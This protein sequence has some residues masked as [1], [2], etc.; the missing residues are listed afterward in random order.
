MKGVAIE[1]VL[2]MIENMPR[3]RL[4][5][6]AFTWDPDKASENFKKHGVTFL[7][8]ATSFL[9]PNGLDG[10]DRLDPSREELIAY[11]EQQRLL[12]TVYVEVDGEIIRIISARRATRAERRAY[13]ENL[14]GGKRATEATTLATYRWRRNPYALALRR[15]GVRILSPAMPHAARSLDS[16]R[17]RRGSN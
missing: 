17:R 16:W 5:D 6:W 2:T 14:R 4:V 15:T 13:E 3:L 9:D 12:L 7:E 10:V 11:S 8:A 1:C